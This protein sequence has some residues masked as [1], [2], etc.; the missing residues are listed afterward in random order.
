[1]EGE[2]WNAGGAHRR[3]GIRRTEGEDVCA[4][5]VVDHGGEMGSFWGAEEEL[6]VRHRGTDDR[7]C[8]PGA[9]ENVER[10]WGSR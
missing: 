10:V 3:A 1:M 7:E 5:L 6:G 8:V 2:V 4:S 9:V